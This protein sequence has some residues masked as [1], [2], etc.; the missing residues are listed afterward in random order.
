MTETC[1]C[2]RGMT[3]VAL[4]VWDKEGYSLCV[5]CNKRDKSGFRKS[6]SQ[7]MWEKISGICYKYDNFAR[8]LKKERD[9]REF[10]AQS[11]MQ[12]YNFLFTRFD[13]W[14]NQL[15]DSKIKIQKLIEV[16]EDCKIVSEKIKHNTE[17]LNRLLDLGS[18]I[19]ELLKVLS[20]S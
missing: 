19:T 11:V 5:V 7:M 8:D 20:K 4:A 2:S 15:V 9:E 16:I 6:E 12:E 14:K 1:N 13:T 17:Y 3:K 18:Q 10:I